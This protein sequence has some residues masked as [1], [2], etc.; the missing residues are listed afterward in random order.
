M[1]IAWRDEL[2]QGREL[3]P[4]LQERDVVACVEALMLWL[5]MGPHLHYKPGP[6]AQL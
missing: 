3:V 6:R 2:R 5:A 4:H 1:N